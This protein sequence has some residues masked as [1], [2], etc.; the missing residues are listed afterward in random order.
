MESRLGSKSMMDFEAKIP[1]KIGL[2][3][4]TVLDLSSFKEIRIE[5]VLTIFSLQQ[6]IRSGWA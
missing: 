5:I 4:Y 1:K 3:Y 2:P 6:Q